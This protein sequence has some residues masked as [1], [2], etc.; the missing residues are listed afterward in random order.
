MMMVMMVVMMVAMLVMMMM[1][2]RMVVMMMVMVV[3]CD[4][5]AH[6]RLAQRSSAEQRGKEGKGRLEERA[7]QA[8]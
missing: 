7:G 6:C 1:T 3:G 2:T 5:P 4:A 8:R